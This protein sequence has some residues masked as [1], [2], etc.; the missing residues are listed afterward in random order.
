MKYY[1]EES[2]SNFKFWSGGQDRAKLLSDEQF[3]IVEQM[4]EE[5]APEEG[6]SDTAIND[7]FWFDFNTIADW[8]GYKNE[9]CFEKN[10]T[11]QEIN[12]AQEWF[13]S[14]AE[15]YD[16]FEFAGMNRQDY[17]FTNDDGEEEM[18]YDSAYDDFVEWW[19]DKSEIEQ[20]EIF[21]NYK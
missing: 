15:G 6:W 16:F 12:D 11:N 20:V 1:V 2:L 14:V 13:N 4:L 10:I 5:I 9:E 3:D 21:R 18:D 19:E 17:L 7:F 8:L